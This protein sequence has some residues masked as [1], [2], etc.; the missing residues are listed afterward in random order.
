M[1][2][3]DRR[4]LEAA[5]TSAQL[6]RSYVADAGERWRE[7]QKT[8]DAAAKRVEEVGEQLGRVAP[9]QQALIADIPWVQAR[10]MR[11]RIVHDDGHVDIEVLEGVVADDLPIIIA[12][13]DRLLAS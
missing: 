1:D 2:E 5:R 6:A 7:D 12:E 11:D 3:R 4:H 10:A 8:V 9:G 13:I